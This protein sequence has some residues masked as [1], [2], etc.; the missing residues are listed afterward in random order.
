MSTAKRTLRYRE[1]SAPHN[2]C[3][4]GLRRSREEI[5]TIILDLLARANGPMSAYDI[6]ARSAKSG[7]Q[8]F[9]AQVYRTL[10]RLIAQ[11]RVSRIESLSAFTVK[12]EAADICLIDS[13]GHVVGS[14]PAPDLVDRLV[15]LAEASGFRSCRTILEVH[16][17]FEARR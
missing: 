9:P 17:E 11:D 5:E 4:S 10:A 13:S 8:V 14:V 12:Q 16:G 15:E 1:A 2:H 6:S 3:A 7:Q